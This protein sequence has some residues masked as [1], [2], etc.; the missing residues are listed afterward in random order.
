MRAATYAK[1]SR[2][3]TGRSGAPGVGALGDEADSLADVEGLVP[4][5]SAGK[6]LVVQSF[7]PVEEPRLIAVDTWYAVM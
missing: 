3:S 5:G 6:G 1:M 4:R 2:M 7:S